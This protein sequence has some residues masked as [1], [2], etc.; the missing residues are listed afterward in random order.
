MSRKNSLNFFGE[1]SAVQVAVPLQAK[2]EELA[3]KSLISKVPPPKGELAPKAFALG[4][5]QN[6][7]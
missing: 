4:G 6:M 2:L 5:S 3:L 7:Y 1:A